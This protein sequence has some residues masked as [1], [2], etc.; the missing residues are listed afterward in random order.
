[1]KS[2]RKD[3]HRLLMEKHDCVRLC[4]WVSELNPLLRV[5]SFYIEGSLWTDQSQ[6]QSLYLLIH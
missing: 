6:K 4:A 1:M 2:S 5:L 3:S